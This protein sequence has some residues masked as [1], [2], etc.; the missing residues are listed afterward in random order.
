M[1]S[2]DT[3]G[4]LVRFIGLNDFVK[5]K[6]ASGRP[7]DLLDIKEIQKKMSEKTFLTKKEAST[8]GKHIDY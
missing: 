1:Q 2:I 8:K 3:D 6:L 7:Q 4:L 5:N